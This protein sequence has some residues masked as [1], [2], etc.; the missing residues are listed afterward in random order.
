MG[1]LNEESLAELRSAG[2]SE[3]GNR[4]DIAIR[5]SRLPQGHIAKSLHVAP[6][7][8]SNLKW[9]RRKR[10]PLEL[11]NRFAEYFGCDVGELFPP[12]NVVQ[13]LTSLPDLPRPVMRSRSPKAGT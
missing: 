8:I 5:L 12:E 9:G 1:V 7:L 4:L 11:A 2:I 3:R 6:T 13:R 10:L